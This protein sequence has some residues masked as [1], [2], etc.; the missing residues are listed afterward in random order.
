M[1]RRRRILAQREVQALVG[2][3]DVI[4][5]GQRLRGR[6]RQHCRQSCE[7]SEGRGPPVHGFRS[8]LLVVCLPPLWWCRPVHFERLQQRTDMNNTRRTRSGWPHILAAGALL[9]LLTLNVL[10]ARPDY[11]WD[12]LPYVAVA[13]QFAGASPGQSHERTFALVQQTLPAEFRQL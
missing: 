13:Y 3:P 6:L 4:A 7:E 10:W 11:N 9:V 8:L 5:R 1:K 2:L 12:M